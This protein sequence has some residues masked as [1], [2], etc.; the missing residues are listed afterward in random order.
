MH[1]TG[2]ASTKTDLRNAFTHTHTHTQNKVY[3]QVTLYTGTL[4]DIWI[5]SRG[6]QKGRA[7]LCK[8]WRRRKSCVC[9]SSTW[10]LY[11]PDLH[12]P[13]YYNIRYTHVKLKTCFHN[14]VT[15]EAQ[16][17]IKLGVSN[18]SCLRSSNAVCN[19]NLRIIM[20]FKLSKF[21]TKFLSPKPAT[22][23]V[24]NLN[25]PVKKIKKYRLWCFIEKYTYNMNSPY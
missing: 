25:K 15:K 24:W 8:G 1:C 12:F 13:L 21:K 11:G 4:Y 9:D 7:T 19:R 3:E 10:Y 14:N 22:C 17:F 18:T 6:W 2:D 16:Q 20:H 5:S 23:F